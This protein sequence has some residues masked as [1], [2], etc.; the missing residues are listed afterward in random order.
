MKQNRTAFYRAITQAMMLAK[1]PLSKQ[2]ISDLTG[3]PTKLV[4]LDLHAMQGKLW[5]VECVMVSGRK[6]YTLSA[7]AA[8]RPQKIEPQNITPKPYCRGCRWG[9]V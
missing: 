9:W 7:T 6:M 3:I 8:R 4:R 1:E 5:G 2:R